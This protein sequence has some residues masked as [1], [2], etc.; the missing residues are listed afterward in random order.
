MSYA[1]DTDVSAEKSRA[2]LERTLARYGASSFGYMT[3]EHRAAVAFKAHGKSVRFILPI[4][5]QK[6][7]EKTANGQR[8]PNSQQIAAT[9][10]AIRSRWRALNLCVKAKLE[11]VECGITSFEE[12][13]LAHFVLPNG[14]TVGETTIPEIEEMSRSGKMSQLRL[15]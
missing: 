13:F 8:R 5:T 1:K 4:P 12:E 9:E 3:D 6:E 11:A 10:Q 15:Q 2:E 14:K 7:F